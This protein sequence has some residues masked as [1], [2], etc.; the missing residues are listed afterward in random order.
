[1]PEHLVSYL[2]GMVALVM[3]S[4]AIAS[5]LPAC[6]RMRA[7]GLVITGFALLIANAIAF[8]L[9]LAQ[10]LALLSPPS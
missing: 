1:M 3:V 8:G 2:L 7:G 4:I 9:G 5:A 10:V 6:I